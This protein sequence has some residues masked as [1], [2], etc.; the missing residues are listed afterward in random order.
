MKNSNGNRL[1]QN[2][3]LPSTLLGEKDTH[4]EV[5]S[6]VFFQHRQGFCLQSAHKLCT[7]AKYKCATSFLGRKLVNTSFCANSKWFFWVCFR[8]PVQFV[9][10][11]LQTKAIQEQHWATQGTRTHDAFLHRTPANCQACEDTVLSL[12]AIWD[13]KI[14][15]WAPAQGK[16]GR[17]FL[18]LSLVL[19]S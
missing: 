6:W 15:A 11:E 2:R 13:A 12:K 19:C 16:W 18:M 3:M 8:L 17:Q 9:S 14:I 7:L 1:Q 4:T 10:A 5:E